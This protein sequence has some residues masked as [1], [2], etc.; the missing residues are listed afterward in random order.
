MPVLPTRFIIVCQARTGSTLLGSLVMAHHQIAWGGEYFKEIR[1][2]AKRGLLRRLFYKFVYHFPVLYLNIQAV[3]HHRPAFGVKLMPHY[4]ANFEKALALFHKAGWRIINLQRENQFERALSYCVAQKE[5]HWISFENR[6]N[7]L[8]SN[9]LIEP[10]AF[11]GILRQQI[12]LAELIQASLAGIPHLPLVYETDLANSG[13][14]QPTIER[15][16][17]YLDLPLISA[18]A[19]VRKT[20][21]RSYQDIVTNY[22]DLVEAVRGSELAFV[23][24]AEKSG[25]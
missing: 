22:A 17:S 8:S 7:P 10:N 1:R 9:L 19:A 24:P 5:M 3:L 21:D 16:C 2:K 14:W 23:L 18:Q 13:C 15:V 20:W 11:L 25:G 4:A 6:T 12:L